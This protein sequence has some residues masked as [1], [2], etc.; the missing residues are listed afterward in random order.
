MRLVVVHLATQRLGDV[1]AVVPH[2]AVVLRRLG[3][4][5]VPTEFANLGIDLG[6]PEPL[7]GRDRFGERR[8]ERVVLRG[9]EPGVGL[10]EELP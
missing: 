9:H 5:E 3:R 8:I 7:M 1:D 6:P 2:S 4:P 10:I